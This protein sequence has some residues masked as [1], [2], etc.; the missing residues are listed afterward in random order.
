MLFRSISI[1]VL[2]S[3]SILVLSFSVF[4]CAI[5]RLWSLATSL[6][7]LHHI[8]DGT[9]GVHPLFLVDLAV[10]V[11]IERLKEALSLFA[12]LVGDLTLFNDGKQL[13]NLKHAIF[14]RVKLVKEFACVGLCLLAVL[15]LTNDLLHNVFFLLLALSFTLFRLTLVFFFVIICSFWLYAFLL[16]LHHIVDSSESLRPLVFCHF[17]ILVSIESL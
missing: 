8:V 17:S 15:G 5:V 12:R 11:S 10:L 4:D 3:I 1:F 14:G 9:E 13:V 2:R 7:L 6:L 16:I